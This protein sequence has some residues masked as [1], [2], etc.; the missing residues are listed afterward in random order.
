MSS[1]KYSTDQIMQRILLTTGGDIEAAYA[2]G[3]NL[4]LNDDEIARTLHRVDEA[5]PGLVEELE[6]NAAAPSDATATR[7]VRAE[8]LDET[9]KRANRAKAQQKYGFLHKLAP[10]LTEASLPNAKGKQDN[11]ARAKG[12]AG[13]VLSFPGRAIVGA[14]GAGLEGWGDFFDSD[15]WRRLPSTDMDNPEGIGNDKSSW[16]MFWNVPRIAGTKGAEL[17][18]KAAKGFADKRGKVSGLATVFANSPKAQ[19]AARKGI[20]YGADFGAGYLAN[21]P[22]DDNEIGAADAALGT[23]VGGAIDGGRFAFGRIPGLGRLNPA[24]GN[25][26][27]FFQM[28]N[29]VPEKI[30]RKVHDWGTGFRKDGIKTAEEWLRPDK[31]SSMKNNLD[32]EVLLRE[33]PNGRAPAIRKGDTQMDVKERIDE[34]VQAAHDQRGQLWKQTDKR[35][36][37]AVQNP[38]YTIKPGD[39]FPQ[40]INMVDV[41]EDYVDLIT[42][43]VGNGK[44]FS[45]DDQNVASKFWEKQANDA[46]EFATGAGVF[47]KEQPYWRAKYTDPVTGETTFYRNAA[48][49]PQGA[50]F[51]VFVSPHQLQ[52]QSSRLYDQHIR[53]AKARMKKNEG[54]KPE[55]VAAT[56]AH[57]AMGNAIA[58]TTD[59]FGA[60]VVPDYFATRDFYSQW[61]PWQH[62]ANSK[63]RDWANNFWGNHRKAGESLPTRFGK[64]A[65]EHTFPIFSNEATAGKARQLYDLGLML[66]GFR[67]PA[68]RPMRAGVAMM[69]P[70]GEMWMRHRPDVA[71]A[72]ESAIR[73][74]GVDFGTKA[75]KDLF[76]VEDM[77]RDAMDSALYEIGVNPL[78]SELYNAI[79]DEYNRRQLGLEED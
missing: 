22:F 58:E 55:D 21:L 2:I 68:V 35:F 23:G 73:A 51:G 34:T 20:E 3:D 5:Y 66:E 61:L 27:K 31:T 53:D 24:V 56:R 13:D 71:P 4:G 60:S 17:L 26:V 39:D 25:S 78:D 12:L 67:M 70:V 48:D 74:T 40:P 19:T 30:E 62:V 47:G 69:R 33:G 44:L 63:S 57:E 79:L 1:P 18:T 42:K 52:L 36:A 65:K 7:D 64:W 43:D 14:L 76:G 50:E 15:Y 49:A 41:G 11:W 72:V 37:D 10:E 6:R 77:R 46:E 54:V 75:V 9:Q 32:A 45:V 59:K 38:T 29:H 28:L 16:L 8:Y